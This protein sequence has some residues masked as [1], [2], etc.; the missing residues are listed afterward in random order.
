MWVLTAMSEKLCQK[1]T[2]KVL[3]CK[4]A[5]CW[6]TF[7]VDLYYSPLCS[8]QRLYHHETKIKQTSWLSYVRA[9]WLVPLYLCTHLC[10]RSFQNN[11]TTIWF[12][13]SVLG[14]PFD[15]AHV[16]KSLAQVTVTLLLYIH[17]ENVNGIAGLYIINGTEQF[18]HTKTETNHICAS[19]QQTLVHENTRGE[20]RS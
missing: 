8:C 18:S 15:S 16:Q 3:D 5:I 7:L 10:T 2:G 6:F 1:N 11:N 13:S 14:V 19:L 20:M 12:T 17:H 4:R 9:R